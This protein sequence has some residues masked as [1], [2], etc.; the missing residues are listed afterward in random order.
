MQIATSTLTLIQKRKKLR[1][2]WQGT[3]DN[4]LRS[5]I[6]SIKE[7]IDSAIKEQLSNTWKKTLQSLNT[8]NMKDTWR[9]T[10][11]LTNANPNIQPLPINDKTAYITQEKLNAFGNTLEHIFTTNPDFDNS[12]TVR[13]EQIVND[14]VKQPMTDRVNY[15]PISLLHSL[16]KFFEKIVLKILNFQRP[17]RII[18]P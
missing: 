2:Q 11:C 10:K 9:I 8:N 1:E 6:N 15:R 13:T 18:Y 5:L 17:C 14:F 3:R 16:G 12:F 4:T 7:Q